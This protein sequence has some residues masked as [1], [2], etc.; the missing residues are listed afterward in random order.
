MCLLVANV[1]PQFAFLVLDFAK[2]YS[3]FFTSL[4]ILFGSWLVY[5]AYFMMGPAVSFLYIEPIEMLA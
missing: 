3:F 5:I 2:W 1:M 4:H